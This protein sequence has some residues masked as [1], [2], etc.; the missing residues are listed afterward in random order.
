MTQEVS[1]DFTQRVTRTRPV[2]G[3]QRAFRRNF[4]SRQDIPEEIVD[5]IVD[6]SIPARPNTAKGKRAKA[7][8][9]SN[10]HDF[11]Y[12][13]EDLMDQGMTKREAWED[14][15]ETLRLKNEQYRRLDYNFFTWGSP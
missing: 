10:I 5:W 3:R 14:A 6:F 13:V 15:L 7:T 9:M 4:W 1:I 12:F 8:I 2:R 11:H